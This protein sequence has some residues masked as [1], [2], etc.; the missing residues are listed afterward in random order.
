MEYLVGQEVRAFIEGIA[1]D[2]GAVQDPATIR[3][4]VRRGDG[5]LDEHAVG[6]LTHDAVGAYSKALVATPGE[7]GVWTWRFE[8]TG[9]VVVAE[10]VYTV[11]ASALL[12]GDRS[13][14]RTGP[15]HAWT[16]AD[17]LERIGV[18]LADVDPGVVDRCVDAASDVMF[19]LGGQRWPGVCDRTSR[20]GACVGDA[21]VPLPEGG[22]VA[23][24]PHRAGFFCSGGRSVELAYPVVGVSEVRVDGDALDPSAYSVRDHRWLVRSDGGTWPCDSRWWEDTPPMEVNYSFGEAPPP[25]GGL[26]AA[27]L[28][29]E[30]LLAVS[31]SSECRLNARVSSV[32]REG[33]TMDMALAGLVEALAGG[34]TGIPEIDLFVRAHNPNRLTRPP[35]VLGLRR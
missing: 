5:T 13:V 20:V 11:V 32:V 18:D 24:R 22:V 23:L 15:C 19:Q 28:A 2:E 29:R 14:P 34:W 7:E 9:P 27:A 33:L 26:A 31:G 3:L 8:T 35:R 4:L 6:A 12:S 25:M 16:D 30:L 21:S 1:P 10:G 17:E